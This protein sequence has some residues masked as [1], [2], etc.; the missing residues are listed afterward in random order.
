MNILLAW[1]GPVGA[2]CFPADAEALETLAGAGVYLRVKT[3]ANGR[4]VSYVGQSRNLVSRIDQHLTALLGLQAPLRDETGAVL[5]SGDFHDRV[6]AYNDIAAAMALAAAEAARMR[7]YVARCGEAFADDRLN[8]VESALKERL[9]AVVA[10]AAGL[11]DCENRQG[12]AAG[13]FD[14]I[15]AIENDLGGLAATDRALLAGILGDEPIAI[16]AG[17]LGMG[18]AE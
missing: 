9:E 14:D 12:I 16:A 18:F 13:D 17:A 2:G 1:A 4:T 6:R 7:F 5:A 15:V 10:G 11:L 3:Y 8:L